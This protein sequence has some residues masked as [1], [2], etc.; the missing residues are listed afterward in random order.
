MKYAQTFYALALV[1][2]VAAPAFA[3]APAGASANPVSA[4]LAGTLAVV[5]GNIL[6]S[7]EQVPENLYSFKPTPEVRT[8]GQLFGHIADANF[9]ICATIAGEKSPMTTS[10]EK[11]VTTKAGL[12]TAL[13]ESFA[14]C[15]KVYGA[16]A[17]VDGAK[18]VDLFGMKMAKLAAL[19]FNTAH[20]FEHYGNLVT[21][22]RLNKMV[23]PSSQG[24]GM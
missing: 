12:A 22:L 20:N 10:V 23:P 3:Q 17:D 21:Y 19:G 1:T 18:M 24:R 9:M 11:T 2:I 14:Y 13:S 4:S 6:K 15:D 7:A 5:K 8:F 16:T